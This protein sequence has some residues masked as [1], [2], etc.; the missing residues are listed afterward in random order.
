LGKI[1]YY[2]SQSP[3]DA[4]LQLF[5]RLNIARADTTFAVQQSDKHGNQT[6]ERNRPDARKAIGR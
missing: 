4:L 2:F 5:Q 3:P 6:A 1:G